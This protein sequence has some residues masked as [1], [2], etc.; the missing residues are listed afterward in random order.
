MLLTLLSFIVT[1][2]IIITVHEFGHFLA[3]R[4]TRMRVNRFSIGFP[5]KLYSKKIGETEF[6]IAWIPLGGFVQIAGMVDE[7]GDG[8]EIT[9]APDEFMSK[10]PLQKIFVLSAGVIMN[11]ILAFCIIAGLTA[12]V[13]VGQ[14]D[15]TLV[16]EVISEMPA[17]AA[18]VHA[19]D[20]IT[21]VNGV[22]TPSWEK[23]VEQISQAGDSVALTLSR[24]A[25][26]Q[27]L[28]VKMPTTETGEKG[29]HHRVIGIAAKVHLRPATPLD[30]VRR[31]WG[32][33]YSTSLGI[34]DFLKGIAT[35]ESSISQLAGPVGVARLSGESVREG[36][37][38]FLFFIAYV[39]V[40]IA[41][42]NILPFPA[43]DGGHIMYVLI[44]AVIRRPI[45]TRIKLWIQ[46]AGMALLILLVLFVSYHDI[47]RIF[48]N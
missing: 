29:A 18:G 10:N 47:M 24:N 8:G 15:G 46:Q 19:G 7:S 38:A 11:Y 27:L 22:A 32:F 45:P 35:G 30:V 21:A 5:P 1:I 3:A 12:A 28:T 31:G 39:S 44:E 4:L 2:G 23:V 16:G 26:Q 13:G 9:G 40:S 43:L 36:S 6:S 20:Q 17:M 48:T 41:F 37:G 33:C 14:V 42:L 25:G 34:V